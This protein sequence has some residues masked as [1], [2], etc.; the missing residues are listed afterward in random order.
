MKWWGVTAT[1]NHKQAKKKLGGKG[2]NENKPEKKMK[3]SQANKMLRF[4]CNKQF[5]IFSH[6]A[7]LSAPL[8]RP[9]PGIWY[10]K[11]QYK[12]HQYIIRGCYRLCLPKPNWRV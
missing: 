9:L 2:G 4:L 11:T 10:P 8:Q 3:R 6:W 12:V 5:Q 1:M 7:H